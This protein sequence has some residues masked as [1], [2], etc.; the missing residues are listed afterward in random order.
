MTPAAVETLLVATDR[1]VRVLSNLGGYGDH[2]FISVHSMK[3]RGPLQA[4]V[5]VKRQK[6]TI[7]QKYA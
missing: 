3:L 1:V 7:Y 4:A 2:E 5:P 6:R